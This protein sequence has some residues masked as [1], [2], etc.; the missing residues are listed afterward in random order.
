MFNF[1][2]TNENANENLAWLNPKCDTVD[3]YQ[4]Q[5]L[6]SE[7]P[8]EGQNPLW[9]RGR[10]GE[11]CLWLRRVMRLHTQKI[12]SRQTAHST[13]E[14]TW[15]PMIAGPEANTAKRPGAVNSVIDR[16]LD[17]IEVSQGVR[18]VSSPA[19]TWRGDMFKPTRSSKA[20]WKCQ[21]MLEYQLVLI[22]RPTRKFQKRRK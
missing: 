19:R 1:P 7:I 4:T 12:L 20:G 9:H 3:I 15:D 18:P 2:T 11:F 6:S 8:E 14:T 22:T 21:V 13:P 10:K 17:G 16:W 5:R